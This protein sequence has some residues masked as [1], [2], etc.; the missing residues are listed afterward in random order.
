MLG[1]FEGTMILLHFAF[2]FLLEMLCRE[3][4]CAH[5]WRHP[6]DHE[7][8]CDHSNFLFIVYELK[9]KLF[10]PLDQFNTCSTGGGDKEHI[11]TRI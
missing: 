9:I 6:H 10:C 5:S 2:N 8:G 3:H 11:S 1:D 4:R 7:F